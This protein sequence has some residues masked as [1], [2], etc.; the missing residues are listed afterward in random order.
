MQHGAHPQ[1]GSGET[2]AATM[3]SRLTNI[4]RKLDEV[5]STGKKS[6]PPAPA[7]KKRS[8]I[9]SDILK[10]LIP[11]L[12]MLWATYEIKD[13]VDMA[14]RERQL[15]LQNV[16]AMTTLQSALQDPNIKPD[17]A[18]K[19]AVQLAGFGRYS[20]PFF[21]NVLDVGGQVA[22][23]KGEQGLRMVSRSEPEEVCTAMTRIITN[24]TGLYTWTTHLKA[25][26]LLGET[27]CGSRY[28]EVSAY[29]KDL[30]SVTVLQKWVAVPPTPDQSEYERLAKQAATS[31][32]LLE[33]V[34]KPHWWQGFRQGDG[35]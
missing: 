27:G 9:W 16:Q 23:E 6:E 18:T 20:I 12:V 3:E 32:S 17:D 31:K 26:V 30:S 2:P 8:G 11:S 24:H 7:D 29:A 33:T 21:V 14:F 25:L 5:A 35:R 1:A 4:E 28:A 15:Q 13:S 34:P 22:K 10:T 19:D